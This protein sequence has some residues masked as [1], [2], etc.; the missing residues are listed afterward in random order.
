[1]VSPDEVGILPLHVVVP[2]TDWRDSFRH[3]EWLIE[4]EPTPENHLD[5]PSAA[6]TL[7]VRS[8][9]ESRFIKKLGKV[10]ADKNLAISEGLKCVLG[11]RKHPQA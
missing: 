9:T 5:K 8:L 4:I 3:S 2:L 11:L 10:S 6:D 7:Q 1:M